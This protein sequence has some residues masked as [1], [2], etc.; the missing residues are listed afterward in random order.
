MK[1]L[2]KI[3][4]VIDVVLGS[5]CALVF[6]LMVC[7]GTYQIVKRLILNDPSTVSEELLTYSFTWMALL[8]SAYVF[9]KRD[10]MRM[11]FLADKLTGTPRK[12]LEIFIELLLMVFTG[13]VLIYGGI[14][15]INLTMIQ[16][17][18]SLGIPM[19]VVYTILPIT[20][21]IIFIYSILNIIDL[22]VG[23]EQDHR[24]VKE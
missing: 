15:I 13:V 10:H 18:A 9:G 7:I 8:A 17:T 5:A 24:D 16:K 12:I 3:R 23:K 11:G 1:V 14:S 4:K 6:A 2:A 19:G 20:G 21:V 22:C